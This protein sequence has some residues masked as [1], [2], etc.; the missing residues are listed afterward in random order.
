MAVAT[1]RLVLAGI[2]K[3]F[4]GVKAL[5]NVSIDL[6]PGEIHAL[7]GENG[8]GKS[9]LMNILS[10]NL[11]PDDGEIFLHGE[12]IALSTP[13][14]AQKQKIAIVHQEKSLVGNLSIA[15]NIFAENYPVFAGGMIDFQKLYSQTSALLEKLR[16]PFL[17]PRTKVESLSSTR[18]QIVEIAKALSKNPQILILD[19]PTAAMTEDETQTLFD[20]LREQRQNGTSI[21]YISHRLAEIFEIADRVS[22]LRDGKHQGTFPVAE[23]N[24]QAI[25]RLMVGRDLEEPPHIHHP[26]E[27]V[28]LSVKNLSGLRFQ[29]ISFDLYAGEILAIAGLIGA[30]RSEVARA[31]MKIDPVESG[32]IWIRGKKARINNPPDAIRYGIGYVPEN[33]KEQ[34][35][36]PEMSVAENVAVTSLSH[37]TRSGFIKKNQLWATVGNLVEKFRI[38]TPSIHQKIIN[39]SGGNQQKA[40]LA[41]WLMLDPAILI[42]DE[43]TQGVDVGAKAEIYQLLR[44]LTA[45]GTAIL[46]ISSELPE[47]LTLSDRVLVMYNGTLTGELSRENAT[48]QEILHLASGLSHHSP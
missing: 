3:S 42:V 23:M 9:T 16:V 31:I 26:R 7:C 25:I 46:L 14:I 40:M 6:F 5:D 8:A 12:K 11:P 1:S 27:Q 33:R 34:G 44:A 38:K 41:R 29:N 2:S 35:I 24:V 45:K 4:P 37:M 48:E 32:E 21:I 15:E 13:L 47:V 28:L 20:I 17:N 43:P 22:I 19:E 18:Q 39:L 10:G 36:F 30:G